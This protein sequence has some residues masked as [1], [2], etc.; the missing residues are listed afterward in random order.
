MQLRLNPFHPRVWR[1]LETPGNLE[2][3]FRI[4][5]DL[6]K[7]FWDE[8]LDAAEYEGVENPED[9]QRPSNGLADNLLQYL[10]QWIKAEEQ[11]WDLRETDK[12]L[13]SNAG[14]I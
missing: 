7:A 13:R 3:A 9:R 12:L 8:K 5:L 10:V 14:C 2:V 6:A 4:L 11:G 1:V